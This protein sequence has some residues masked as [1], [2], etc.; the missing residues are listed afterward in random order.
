MKPQK[1]KQQE[2]EAESPVGHGHNGDLPEGWVVATLDELRAPDGPIIYGILQP[3]PD[4]KGGVPYIRPTEI[5][6]DCIRIDS[7]RRTTPEI[8][9]KYRRA[10]LR[11][12]DVILTIVGSIGKVA[13]VP[14]VLDGANLTQSSARIRPNLELIDPMLLRFGLLSR[15]MIKQYEGFELGSAVP[16]LNLEDVRKLVFRVPPLA[17]QRR[18]VTKLE[19]LLG[20]VSSSQRR[21]SRIPDLLKRFRQSVLAAACSGNLTADWR[22]VNDGNDVSADFCAKIAKRRMQAWRNQ[23]KAKGQ[24]ANEAEYPQ[25]AEP[26]NEFEFDAPASWI[27]CSMDELTAIITSGSRDW[28]QYYRDDGPGTFIMAQNVRPLRFDRS[29]RLAVAPP[30]DDR[31]RVR[32]EVLSGDLLVTIVGANTGDVCRVPEK[33]EQ[34]YVCQSVALMRPVLN[35]TAPFLE[36]FLNSTGHGLAQYRKW[37]YGEGRPHLSFDHLRETAIMLPPLAEQQEIVRRVETL[38]AFAD[39]IE[40]RL[41]L[42]QKHVD[43]ITQS[44]LAKAFRGELV[45]TEHVLAEAEGRDYEPASALLERLRANRSD[46]DANGN[47][48]TQVRRRERRRNKSDGN[49]D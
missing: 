24:S 11:P 20:K 1:V 36:L 27:K 39:Q 31:D 9:S 15:E 28:K 16:R 13:I 19:L 23:R 21:L 5:V 33:L 8:A 4:I 41:Q 43:R 29:Y 6:N 47:A 3:G 37:I 32:S 42:A 44:L 25:P 30:K 14:P 17:E 34:H 22:E 7:L 35:E 2:Q 48:T 38:F 40:A 10:T 49:A 46:H 18:I 26:T 45:P 12:D